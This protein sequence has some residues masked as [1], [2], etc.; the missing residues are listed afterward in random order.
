MGTFQNVRWQLAQA[1]E[2]RWWRAYLKRKPVADYLEEKERY[3]HRVLEEM[4]WTVAPGVSVADVGCGPA[5]VYIA[6][7]D[8]QRVTAIDPLLDRYEGLNVFSRSAYPAVRFL[9]LMLED[10]VDLG[11]FRQLYC[12]NAINHVRDWAAGLDAL[13]AMA[14]PGTELLLTSDVHRHAWLLPIFRALP[15]DALH[16]QQHGAG[17]YRNALLD[18]GWRIDGERV[19]RR[20]RIFQYHAWKCTMEKG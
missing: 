10:A 19:L 8:R 3:W 20:E 17:A 2:W 1:L 11:P 12:F 6:L 7:H 16:P 4:D 15:G 14:E 9:P 18:R 13:T 5:G